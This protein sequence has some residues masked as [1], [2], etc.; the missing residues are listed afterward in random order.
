MM[1]D[2]ITGCTASLCDETQNLRSSN[3][4]S[5]PV[6]DPGTGEVIGG[7]FDADAIP[8]QNSDAMLAHLA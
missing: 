2:A 7:H 5:I 4:L 1:P 8:C 3:T 6:S